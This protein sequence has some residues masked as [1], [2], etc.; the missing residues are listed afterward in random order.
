[1]QR[2]VHALVGHLALELAAAGDARVLVLREYVFTSAAFLDALEGDPVACRFGH[3]R[4]LKQEVE[5]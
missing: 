2:E 1:M 3:G 5:S 4:E